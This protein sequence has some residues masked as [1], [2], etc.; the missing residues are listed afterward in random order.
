MKLTSN[1]I[2]VLNGMRTNDFGDILINES[3]EWTFAVIDAS[4]LEPR[5]AR[6]AISSLIKK[7]LVTIIRDT[8]NNLIDLTVKGR[9]LFQTLKRDRKSTRLNSS[10]ANISYAVFCLKKKKKKEIIT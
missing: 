2:K 10:H 5:V 1:E 3:A 6:G 7:E 4:K 8:P 9:E